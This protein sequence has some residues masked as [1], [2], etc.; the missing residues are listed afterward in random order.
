MAAPPAP[1]P[2]AEL[3]GARDGG[4]RRRD[5]RR[6]SARLEVERPDRDQRRSPACAPAGPG[7]VVALRADIDALPI[8]EESGVEFASERP[9]VDARLRARRPHRDA[10]RRGARAGGA[11][12]AARRRGALPL[13][14]RR[15]A[16]AR[17]RARPRRGRRRWRA[18]TSSTAATC[19]RRWRTARSP[20][21][22]GPVHG[23]RGLLHARRSPAAAGTPGSRTPPIDTIAS[24]PQVVDEPAARRLAPDRPARSPRS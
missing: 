9:G 16:R 13:P 8:H 10:A 4:V 23:R 11:R 21:M 5:A 19:G 1:P 3:R 6:A 14:A 22:P 7:R 20:P 2:R 18:S 24:P 17:R 12:D 15:G